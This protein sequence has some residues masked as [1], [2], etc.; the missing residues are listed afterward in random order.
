MMCNEILND[1]TSILRGLEPYKD[2]TGIKPHAAYWKL[3]GVIKRI[4]DMP[5]AFPSGDDTGLTATQYAAI[6]LCVPR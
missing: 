1:L 6:H 3:K 4:E 5:A 2:E